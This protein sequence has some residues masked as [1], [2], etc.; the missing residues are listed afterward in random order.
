MQ[1]VSVRQS[2][3]RRWTRKGRTK[4]H[5]GSFNKTRM[6]YRRRVYNN[7]NCVNV[8]SLKKDCSYRMVN[9]TVRVY[10]GVKYLSVSESSTGRCK[11]QLGELLYIA[12]VRKCIWRF[13]QMYWY[14][15]CII[16]R[17]TWVCS[18]IWIHHQRWSNLECQSR[19]VLYTSFIT[20]YM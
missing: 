11:E 4:E 17:Q 20:L 8:G 10:Q 1:L 7:S 6:H 12:A 14:W 3:I 15:R 16:E 9:V 5:M 19:V 18:W 2:T 13:N